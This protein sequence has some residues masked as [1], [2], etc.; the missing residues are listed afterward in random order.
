MK[1]LLITLSFISSLWAMDVKQLDAMLLPD[2]LYQGV[3]VEYNGEISSD[4]G[5]V[6]LGILV[7]SNL[8]SVIIVHDMESQSPR[9]ERPEIENRE[10]EQ[11]ITANLD[12][13]PFRIVLFYVPFAPNG[14]RDFEFIFKSD[15]NLESAHLKVQ[16]PM[17]A[18]NFS[19]DL[20]G[21]ESTKDQHGNEVFSAHLHDFRAMSEKRVKI[22]YNN[23]SGQTT[24]EI[25]RTMLNQGG[26]QTPQAA[27]QPAQSNTAPVRHTLPTW[28]PLAVLG[29][30]LF[31]IFYM[32]A[33]K[34]PEK[35]TKSSG[36]KKQYCPSCGKKITS[37]SKFCSSCGKK[38]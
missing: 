12:P 31:V 8:D 30:V 14:A 35:K 10:N 5:I 6:P 2:Y 4:A 18:E 16:K 15:Q 11:W 26:P 17:A 9:L 21:A 34:K 37:N 3:A 33:N 7:P 27:Q 38:I 1:T 28:E 22:S 29:V 25:M 32:Y 13:G 19:I 24:M 20:A 36:D 23:P